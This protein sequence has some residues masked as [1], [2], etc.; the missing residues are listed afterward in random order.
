MSVAEPGSQGPADLV[1]HAYPGRYPDTPAWAPSPPPP[2]LD[3]LGVEASY[4]LGEG[5]CALIAAGSIFAVEDLK[6]THTGEY[7]ATQIEVRARQAGVLSP[8]MAGAPSAI[9]ALTDGTTL[10]RPYVVAFECA[11]RGKGSA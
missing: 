2:R 6:P 5:T 10:D 8:V 11:R 3:R 7:L 4:A 9:S 1:D